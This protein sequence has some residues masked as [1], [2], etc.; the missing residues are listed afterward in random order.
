[1]INSNFGTDWV[2]KH[3]RN[4][5]YGTPVKKRLSQISWEALH[6]MQPWWGGGWSRLV[7]AVY[8]PPLPPRK[9]N[10]QKEGGI[11]ILERTQMA[12]KVNPEYGMSGKDQCRGWSG[13]DSEDSPM[14]SPPSH[15]LMKGGRWGVSIAQ[16]SDYVWRDWVVRV[17][18]GCQMLRINKCI[19]ST[20][21]PK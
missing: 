6:L 4:W 5:G 1:M 2:D 7:L 20:P 10:M 11:D 13:T 8:A 16:P 14:E 18:K 19:E 21:M 12:L 9:I 15:P 3:Q 17:I